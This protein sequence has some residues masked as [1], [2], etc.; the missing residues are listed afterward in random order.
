MPKGGLIVFSSGQPIIWT[1]ARQLTVT[2]GSTEAEY[3]A[4]DTSTQL[5]PKQWHSFQIWPTN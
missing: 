5:G 3:K 4:V 2:H 1:S